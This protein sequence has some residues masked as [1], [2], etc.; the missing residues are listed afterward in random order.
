MEES[1]AKEN[2]EELK[3][4]KQ[5]LLQQQPLPN[6]NESGNVLFQFWFEVEKLKAIADKKLKQKKGKEIYKKYVKTNINGLVVISPADKKKLKE[7][8]GGGKGEGG[9]TIGNI[10]NIVFFNFLNQDREKDDGYYKRFLASDLYK[11]FAGKR[12]IYQLLFI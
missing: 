4:F 12:S 6:S 10:Q 2:N 1:F 8:M 3:Q 5:F 9:N 11:Q 7:E